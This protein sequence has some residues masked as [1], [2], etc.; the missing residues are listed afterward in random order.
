MKRVTA[1]LLLAIILGAI[2]AG[3]A[4]AVGPPITD[5]VV[6]GEN[7]VVIGVKST[8]V[9]LV[10][11]RNNN[12]VTGDAI[13]MN[14]QA[15]IDGDARSGGNVSFGTNASITGKLFVLLL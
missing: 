1:S 8:V 7:G 2:G 11:A 5:Y 14:G 15:K 3:P 12:A 4:A 9:G 13:H 6:F 10:G